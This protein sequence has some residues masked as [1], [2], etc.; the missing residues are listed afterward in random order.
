MG[1]R[2][3][4][5]LIPALANGSVAP[6]TL[7]EAMA[8]QAGL[9]SPHRV[10]WYP[11]PGTEAGYSPSEIP[12]GMINLDARSVHNYQNLFVTN[13]TGV[14]GRILEAEAD[15]RHDAIMMKQ[16]EQSA[17]VLRETESRAENYHYNEMN[18]AAQNFANLQAVT[19][20]LRQELLNQTRDFRKTSL[21]SLGMKIRLQ[22][23]GKA[24][25]A[26][27]ARIRRNRSISLGICLQENLTLVIGRL[28]RRLLEL[29]RSMKMRFEG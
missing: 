10:G 12:P 13:D 19:Q 3:E 4:E 11:R 22:K 2:E 5:E 1:T 29:G 15:R 6:M 26:S 23:N 16:E 7:S 14:P 18:V 9:P 27:S 8:R 28:M 20:Q 25:I 17:A 24:F 21:G